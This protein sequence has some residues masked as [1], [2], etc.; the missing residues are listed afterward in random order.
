MFT[1]DGRHVSIPGP[2]NHEIPAGTVRN[3]LRQLE[4][5]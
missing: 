2:A 4:E 5:D 3:I 1:K